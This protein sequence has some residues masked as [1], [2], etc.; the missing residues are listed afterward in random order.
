MYQMVLHAYKELNLNVITI[1]NPVEQLLKGIKISI[2]K[3]QVSTYVSSFK[4]ILRC[5]PDII[6][7]GEIRDAE[8]AKC[9]I[10]ASLSG[11]LVL[12][13]MHSTNCKGCIT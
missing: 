9:V 3:K 13:T 11:H 5:D 4:A 8:V 2:N 1:E 7:I 6:L 12:S 10:Q